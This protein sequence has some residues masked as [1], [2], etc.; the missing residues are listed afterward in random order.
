MHLAVPEVNV[1]KGVSKMKI[2]L[3]GL[4]FAPE[5]TGIGKYSGEMAAWLA[6]A[7]NE[8]HVIAAPPYYPA[9]SV[10]DGYSA[11]G[12]AVENWNG[13]HVWRTPIW[14]PKRPS[15]LKRLI[16]LA[17]FAAMSVPALVGQMF[18]RPDVVVVIAPAFACAPGGWLAARLCG[19]KAW[20]HV[21]DFEIDAAFRMGL[22]K[23]KLAQKALGAFERW[24]LR[25]FDRVSTISQR[26]LEL[27]H[28]KNVDTARAVSFP[29]WVDIN[30]VTPNGPAGTY[31]AELDIPA[32]AIVALYSGSMAGKQGLELLPAAARALED[33]LPNLVFV[34]CGDGIA[35][36]DIERASAGLRNVRMLPLQPQARLGELLRTADIHL[37]PQCAGA[38]DLVMPSKL[39]GMLSSGRPVLATA[40]VG[41][42][43]A[44]VVSGRGLVVP[45]ADL[46]AFT[47]AL[48]ELSESATMRAQMGAAARHYAEEQLARSRVL[49]DFE[50]ALKRCISGTTSLKLPGADV[51]AP[52]SETAKST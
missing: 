21:Q 39:T 27:L 13:V 25:R 5:P 6:D 12:G 34:L 42:E 35:K 26:M 7:G 9:W 41:T 2:L 49:V 43:L 24:M 37:L 10:G 11:W 40:Q 46:P 38:A 22:L 51:L 4:N 15:G 23:N 19:A 29:N 45:P 32:D 3:Y 48:V 17:S 30:A 14:V 8:I 28:A 33:R 50:I 20:L 31:R 16:H 52:S 18:W 44:T 36:P 47:A 1:L